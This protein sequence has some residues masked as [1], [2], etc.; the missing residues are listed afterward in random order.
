MSMRVDLETAKD[1]HIDMAAADH[2]NDI[3]LSKVLAPGNAL[4]GRR[5]HP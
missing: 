5:P 4:I 3:A 1:G 2:P